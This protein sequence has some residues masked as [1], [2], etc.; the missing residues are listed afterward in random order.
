M[1]GNIAAAAPTGVLPLSLS[2][3][4]TESRVFP[5]LTQ[6][7]HDGT[8]ERS[9]IVD[10][11]NAPASFRTWKLATR[12]TAAQ[13]DTLLAFWESHDGGL[14]PFYYYNPFEAAGAV[15]SN[16]DATGVSTTG[17]HTVVFR[18]NWSQ[19]SG[20][21]LTDLGLEFAEVA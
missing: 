15:G 7:Y 8:I 20:P 19:S 16:Y 3:A 6:S 5:L 12:L 10:G 21:A 18:G 13:A 2:L 11:V 14:T 17:R 1:P 9:L 4:F